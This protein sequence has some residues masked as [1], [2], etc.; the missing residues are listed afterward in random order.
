M[1]IQKLT[2]RI[3]E[4]S[5][6]YDLSHIGSCISVLPILI[7]IYENKAPEDLV[8]LD[9]GH[10][11]LAHYVVLEVCQTRN[12]DGDIIPIDAEELLKKHG[13]HANRDVQFGLHST[14]GSLSHSGIAI[15]LCLANRNRKCYLIVSDGSVA[16]GSFAESLRLARELKLT[17]LEIH[18]NFNG[19]TAVSEVDL[20]YYEQWIKGFGFPV[21]FHR[22]NNGLLE[23]D[24]VKGHYEKIK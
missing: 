12:F 15:G 11:S 13:I 21:V 16:E 9:N 8:L 17:N 10:A 5:K 3:L 20:D 14:N 24:G 18:A 1:E 19:F 7:E 23:F 2:N 4:I 6:K 22:T